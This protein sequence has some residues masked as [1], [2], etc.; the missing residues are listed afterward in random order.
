MED[1]PMKTEEDN[2][3]PKQGIREIEKQEQQE[4]RKMKDTLANAEQEIQKMHIMQKQNAAL[5]ENNADAKKKIDELTEQINVFRA[6]SSAATPGNN[7]INKEFPLNSEIVSSYLRFV[8]TILVELFDNCL[9]T[10]I[11]WACAAS[12]IIFTECQRL[13]RL[14][15]QEP[16]RTFQTAVMVGKFVSEWESRISATAS[17]AGESEAGEPC[18][19]DGSRAYDTRVEPSTINIYLGIICSTLSDSAK[20]SCLAAMLSEEDSARIISCFAGEQ[21]KWNTT[22]GQFDGVPLWDVVAE[23]MMVVME[24]YSGV[25]VNL[26][27]YLH[28]YLQ[29]DMHA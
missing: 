20:T 12:K 5:K 19:A 4:L 7:H 22:S 17:E 18:E 16:Q 13:A 3:K 28:T 1:K 9:E 14:R 6:M 2:R 15:T 10:D 25:H 27:T 26:H 11:L 29:T 21:G 24:G 8:T 23:E